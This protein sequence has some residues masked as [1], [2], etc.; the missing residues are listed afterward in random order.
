MLW[1]PDPPLPPPRSGSAL[2][3]HTA[4]RMIVTSVNDAASG[5]PC[6]T[7]TGRKANMKENSR[8]GKESVGVR[9]WT[10]RTSTGPLSLSLWGP[11]LPDQVPVGSSS[12]RLFLGSSGSGEAT[13]HCIT[14]LSFCCLAY[15]L[16]RCS[17]PRSRR[18]SSSRAP[19]SLASM[20]WTSWSLWLT[21]DTSS[22]SSSCSLCL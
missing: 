11:F 13:A 7:A 1:E 22:C 8:P 14:H 21:R 6:V 18:S 17:R 19:L 3:R 9:L 16:L 10:I 2:L 15:F 5:A 20:L 12:S 4:G